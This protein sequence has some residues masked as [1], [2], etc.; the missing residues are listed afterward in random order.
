M[1]PECSLKVRLFQVDTAEL[2]A[3]LVKILNNH[4]GTMEHEHFASIMVDALDPMYEGMIDLN[5]LRNKRA[6]LKDA[7]KI[8]IN[9]E[10]LPPRWAFSQTDAA[11]FED[12]A[13]YLWDVYE[14]LARELA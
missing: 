7:Y 8:M 1:F 12:L 13:A 11:R 14:S 6:A 2:E 9:F 4:G 10:R 5:S 3:H